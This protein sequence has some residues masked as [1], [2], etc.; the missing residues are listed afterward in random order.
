MPRDPL[1]LDDCPLCGGHVQYVWNDEGAVFELFCQGC[2]AHIRWVGE[3]MKLK[4][5]EAF[6]EQMA[7]WAKKWNRRVD[8]IR[9]PI[10]G[11]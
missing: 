3:D 8:A 1:R 7:R 4:P 5:R 10:Q 2:R 11:Q 6:G 9:T